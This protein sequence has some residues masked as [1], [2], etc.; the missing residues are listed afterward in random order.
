MSE[1]NQNRARYRSRSRSGSFA[2]L[3]ATELAVQATDN[4]RR[5]CRNAKPRPAN[6]SSII[7]HVEG[8]GTAPID[9]IVKCSGTIV[10]HVLIEYPIASRVWMEINPVRLPSLCKSSSNGAVIDDNG[11]NHKL[12][13]SAL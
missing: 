8:S 1:T 10:D 6:P 4:L 9:V 7:A 3:A 2:M 5:D 11:M 12:K 13:Y